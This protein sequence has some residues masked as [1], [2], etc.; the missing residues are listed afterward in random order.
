V[1]GDVVFEKESF[2]AIPQ[3][4][5]EETQRCT[6][7]FLADRINEPQRFAVFDG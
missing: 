2:L 4:Y 7:F 6:E 1:I 5:T 3:R